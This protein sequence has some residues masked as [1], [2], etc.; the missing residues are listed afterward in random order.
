[1]LLILYIHWVGSPERIILKTLSFSSATP[2]SA[3]YKYTWLYIIPCSK[4]PSDN[5]LSAWNLLNLSFFCI[6]PL[7]WKQRKIGILFLL[8]LWHWSILNVTHYFKVPHSSNMM[9]CLEIFWWSPVIS[10]PN[11]K[12][13][14]GSNFEQGLVSPHCTL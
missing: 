3:K 6:M 12:I 1:M 9:H 11:R 8:L 13:F 2:L 4:Q 5:L 10:F 7:L 14:W